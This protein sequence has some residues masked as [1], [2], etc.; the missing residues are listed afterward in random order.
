MISIIIPVYKEKN[1]TNQLA[2]LRQWELVQDIIVVDGD[3]QKQT[4]NLIKD[5]QITCVASQKGRANQMNKGA[6]LA[7]SDTLLFL[8]A[9]TTLPI[10]AFKEIEAVFSKNH[11]IKAMAFD[12]KIDHPNRIYRLIE[13]AASM[14]S[15]LTRIPFGDQAIAI[16]KDTFNELKGFPDVPI[17]EDVMLMHALK[18]KGI[19]IYI[20]RLKAT[21]SSRRWETEGVIK[22]TLK[23]NWMQT[24]YY[25]GIAPQK[26]KKYYMV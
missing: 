7:T 1:I 25:L 15:R 6:A 20:S 12:L 17:M 22:R 23:N 13:K 26:L 3:P 2:S 19:R 8:H 16:K 18:K 11:T 4:I 24:L 5:K 9:D 14:R 10:G 21:T